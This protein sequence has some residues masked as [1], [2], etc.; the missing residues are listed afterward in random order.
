MLH[1]IQSP[2]LA[3]L[4][5]RLFHDIKKHRQAVFDSATVIVPSMV[6][7]DYLGQYF[8]RKE[9]ISARVEYRFW[10]MFQWAL[11]ERVTR[12]EQQVFDQAP[13]S[14]VAMQWRI[15]SYLFERGDNILAQAEHPLHAS[16]VALLSGK[17]TLSADDAARLWTYAGEMSRLFVDYISMRPDWLNLWREQGEN[18]RLE[19]LLDDA[20]MTA[21]P[22]WMQSHYQEALTAQRFLWQ[23]LFA[24]VYAAREAQTADFFRILQEAAQ[25][26][27]LLPPALF[28]FTIVTITPEMLTFLQRLGEF[29]PVYLYHHAISNAYLPDIVDSEWLQRMKLQ[30]LDAEETHFSSGHPLVS[31]FGKQQRDIARLFLGAEL[32]E[33]VETIDVAPPAAP[34]LLAHLQSDMQLLADTCSVQEASA[35]DDDSLQIHGCHGFLRQLEVLRSELVR[36]LNADKSRRLDD[37]LIVVPDI[38]EHQDEI[39]AVFPAFGAY[40]GYQL[41]ARLTG[42]TTPEADNLW[43]AVAGIYTLLENEFTQQGLGDWLSLEPVCRAYGVAHEDMQ[44]IFAA[45]LQAGFRRGFDAAHVKAM[46]ACDDGDDRFTFTYA[47]NRLVAGMTMPDVT[48][49]DAQIVPQ[50][51][52]EMH[53]LPALDALCQIHQ[54]VS[55]LREEMQQHK[56]ARFWLQELQT[57]LNDVF[58]GEENTQ[59]FQTIQQTLRDLDFSLQAND[60]LQSPKADLFLPLSFVLQYVESQLASQQ[61]S[62]EPSGVITIGRLSALRALPY[63]LIAFLGADKDVF[64][65]KDQDQRYNLIDVDKKRA[66]DRNRQQDDLGAFL[67][68][69]NNARTAFWCFYSEYLPRDGE[70]RLPA[71]PV[72]EMLDYLDQ[73]MPTEKQH[74]HLHHS[75]DP[76]HPDASSTHPAPL[77]QKVRAALA[78]ARTSPPEWLTLNV[79]ESLARAVAALPSEAQALQETLRLDVMT[80]DLLRPASTYLRNVPVAGVNLAE[81]KDSFE[82]LFPDS[83]E[84]W[85]IDAAYLAAQQTQTSLQVLQR[86]PL[87]P[88]GRYGEIYGKKRAQQLAILQRRVLQVAGATELTETT[89]ASVAFEHGALLGEMPASHAREW[90]RVSA[91]KPRA[92][93]VFRFWLQHLLWQCVADGRSCIA[94]N[95]AAQTVLEFTP[96][97]M[98]A[99][100]QA[101]AQWLDVWKISQYQA[102]LMPIELA[103]EVLPMPSDKRAEKQAS[104][105]KEWATPPSEKLGGL[106]S[107]DDWQNWNLLLGLETDNPQLDKVSRALDIYAEPLLAE[108]FA[109]LRVVGEKS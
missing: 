80:T 73:Q 98:A 89:A 29:I 69:L 38:D 35:E 3:A 94:F 66:G 72:Q 61:V 82:P 50:Q 37:I 60:A 10:G 23:T 75:A 106:F 107:E 1:I 64:P 77:W 11:I 39:R 68:V 71:A 30:T 83:L 42:V 27:A 5:E 40:D 28:L 7:S 49:Y 51:A 2:H 6:L 59:A 53:D 24:D 56:D 101:L 15:F 47:L 65:A 93:H 76:F 12:G 85:Q 99:A 79:P 34:T 102:W 108:L 88:A 84:K 62:S 44:K 20:Q 57:R 4:S 90:L 92:K 41:P 63:K 14:N 103:Y 97:S 22:E 78:S 8:A 86:L 45:L 55:A 74:Y 48:L 70:K 46:L 33:D 25:P 21:M 91:S 81:S 95:D 67:D 100:H 13:L 104:K 52:L 54:T 31:R 9:G 105:L 17:Q 18:V 96:L 109:H 87:L 16:L 58:A 43:Q 19:A 26:Q 32:L 36:W